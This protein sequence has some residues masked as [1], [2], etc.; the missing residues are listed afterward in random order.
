MFQFRDEL[1]VSS[2]TFRNKGDGKDLLLVDKSRNFFCLLLING[3]VGTI[4]LG[5]FSCYWGTC[6]YDG[7]IDGVIL[8]LENCATSWVAVRT[9][10]IIICKKYSVNTVIVLS[11]STM[12]VFTGYLYLMNASH[13]IARVNIPARG[14]VTAETG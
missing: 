7:T 9:G 14:K 3:S 13:G 11:D 10:L 12:T 8:A 6:R 5:S 4:V 2:S 1:S